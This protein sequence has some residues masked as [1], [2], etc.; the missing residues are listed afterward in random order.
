ML[1]GQGVAEYKAF[2]QTGTWLEADEI[3]KRIYREFQVC[4]EDLQRRRGGGWLRGVAALMLTKYAGM[5][6]A[7]TARW[8]GMGTGA[9]VS[10]RLNA[11]AQQRRREKILNSRVA[12]LE[13][14]MRAEMGI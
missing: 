8:L 1:A 13:R 5:N 6:H 2:R 7:E 10:L 11:L 4:R 12:R 14:E 9:A 3:L